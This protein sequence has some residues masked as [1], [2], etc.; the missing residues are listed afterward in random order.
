MK[1]VK[2]I[3]VLICALCFAGQAM[4]MDLVSHIALHIAAH[5]AVPVVVYGLSKTPPIRM[6]GTEDAVYGLDWGSLSCKAKNV[7][8]AQLSMCGGGVEEDLYGLQVG[9][10][11]SGWVTS[12]K[13]DHCHMNGMQLGTFAAKTATANGFQLSGVYSEANVVN[14]M[15]FA[16]IYEESDEV[17]GFQLSGFESKSRTLRGLGIAPLCLS[18]E[19][20]GVQC[21]IVNKA[22]EVDGVQIGVYNESVKGECL[23]IG[24]VNCMPDRKL[25]YLPV[26]NFRFK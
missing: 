20:H 25:A 24:V 23:Q 10:I 13:L 18:D 16:G 3:I 5:I 9:A 11:A 2:R 6:F 4:A 22:K 7:Y 8:G 12:N 17:N 15:Q 21:G 14:G 1:K 19:V 26:I